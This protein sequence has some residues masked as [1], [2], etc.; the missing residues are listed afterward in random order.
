MCVLGGVRRHSHTP[1]FSVRRHALWS[2]AIYL[3]KELSLSGGCKQNSIHS[4]AV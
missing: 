4:I 1:K 3:E 2:D